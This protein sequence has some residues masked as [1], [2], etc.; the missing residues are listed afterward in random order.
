R[1]EIA[2]FAAGERARVHGENH[3]ERRLVND[4]RLKRIGVGEVGD[5]FAD[6]NAFDAGDGDNVPG[7]DLFGFI[8]FAAAAGEEL[9]DFG[10]LNFSV[11]LGD[12]DFGAARERAIDDAGDGDAAEKFGVVEVHDLELQRGGRIAGGSWDALYDGFKERK[13]IF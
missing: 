4:E 5:A 3:G 6:L 8:A 12:A 13:Q 11:E 1:S 10:G 2:A 7:G 9:G